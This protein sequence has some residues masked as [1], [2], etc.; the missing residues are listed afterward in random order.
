MKAFHAGANACLDALDKAHSDSELAKIGTCIEHLPSIPKTDR[1]EWIQQRR[2]KLE[3][4]LRAIDK[5]D[6]MIDVHFNPKDVPAGSIAPP[7]G[8][9]ADAGVSPE[10]IKDPKLRKQYEEA[11]KANAEKAD[12][13]RLQYGLRRLDTNWSSQAVVFV[14]SE[15]TSK[16]EDVKEIGDLIDKLL[17]NSQR[18]KQMRK[19]IPD[20]IEKSE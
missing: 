9:R 11:L 18:K 1:E 6:R 4:W 2:L 12:R 17:S 13:Y 19:D 8:T 7:M 15:Y 16:P 10:A 20:I 14:K 5:V 3:L